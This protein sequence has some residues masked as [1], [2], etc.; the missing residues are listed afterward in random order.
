[1]TVLDIGCGNKPYKPIFSGKNIDYMGIDIRKDGC[2][3]IICDVKQLP[4]TEA[5]FSLCLCFQVLEHVDDSSTAIKEIL[6]VLCPHG[7]L[8]ISVPSSWVIHGAPHDYWR[9]TS[10]GVKKLLSDFH[11]VELYR[12]RGS[13]G[14]MIQCFELFIPRKMTA[15]IILFNKLGEVLDGSVW[16]ERHL[17]QFDINYFAVAVKG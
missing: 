16:L 1:M 5:S 4:F 10:Y 17:P 12:C 13:V 14:S 15:L 8:F 11:V 2:A 9:W 7:L 6:R 3:D